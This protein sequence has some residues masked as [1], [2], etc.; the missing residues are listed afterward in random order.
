MEN[1]TSSAIEFRYEVGRIGHGL[2]RHRLLDGIQACRGSG[3][4][5]NRVMI[6]KR[7]CINCEACL[8]QYPA[9]C[10]ELN[11]AR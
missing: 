4:N 9:R 8:K 5:N 11:A 2:K 3:R 7:G 6:E 10:A 1:T